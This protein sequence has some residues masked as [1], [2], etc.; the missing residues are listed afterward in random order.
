MKR[1]TV[2]IFQRIILLLCIGVAPSDVLREYF[3]ISIRNNDRVCARAVFFLSRVL[4]DRTA[5]THEEYNNI[6]TATGWVC[7]LS[8]K[9]QNQILLLLTFLYQ[10]YCPDRRI[11][12]A[13]GFRSVLAHRVDPT[14]FDYFPRSVPVMIGENDE[15]I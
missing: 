4:I 11:P 3:I 12:R 14:V 6:Y 8:I 13:V 10:I 7:L 5:R 1:Y 9:I 15:I 2:H